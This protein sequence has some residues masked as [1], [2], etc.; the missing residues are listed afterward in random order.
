MI[1]KN[2]DRESHSDSWNDHDE[3]SPKHEDNN[4]DEDTNFPA[5]TSYERDE[6][7]PS[8]LR[9]D[10]EED[11]DHGFYVKIFTYRRDQMQKKYHFRPKNNF[12]IMRR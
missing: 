10:S 12:R 3:V 9:Y 1:R 4:V 7:V 2:V 11:A 5:F 6:N 8:L